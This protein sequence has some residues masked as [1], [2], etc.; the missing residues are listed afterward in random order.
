MAAVMPL[1]IVQLVLLDIYSIPDDEQVVNLPISGV[2]LYAIECNPKEI[3]FL[4]DYT[5]SNPLVLE[6]GEL[7][8]S[9]PTMLTYVILVNGCTFTSLDN[10]SFQEHMTIERTMSKVLTLITGSG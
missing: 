2:I 5:L 10:D 3:R 6:G 7:L 8:V 4:L 9:E 1:H